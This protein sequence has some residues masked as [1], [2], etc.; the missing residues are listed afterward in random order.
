MVVLCKEVH[1]VEGFNVKYL[2][3]YHYEVLG[4]LHFLLAKNQLNEEYPDNP[5]YKVAMA[6]VYLGLSDEQSLRL[7]QRHNQNSHL[8]HKVTTW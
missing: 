1:T 2:N 7:A 4:G 5:Y 6:E 8:V 3:V